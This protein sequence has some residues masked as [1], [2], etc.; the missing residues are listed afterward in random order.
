MNEIAVAVF[1]IFILGLLSL[2]FVKGGSR[3]YMLLVRKSVHFITGMVIFILTFHVGRDVLLA[4]IALGTVFSFVTWKLKG[5][6]FIHTTSG[7]SLGTLFYPLGILV[8]CML[9]YGMPLYYFQISLLVLA[10]SDTI[11]NLGG[12]I[13]PWN[14]RFAVFSEPKSV[15]GV[16]GFA[17]SALLI[18]ILLLPSPQSGNY[19]YIALF[20]IAAIH[21]EVLSHRGSDN[22]TIPVGCALFFLA[23]DGAVFN[24]LLPVLAIPAVAAGACMVYKKNVLTKYGAVAAYFLGVYF[25]CITGARWSVPVVV[26]FVTSV[27]F[28][29]ING[30]VN[31]KPRDTNRRNVWQVSANIFFAV[32]ASAGYLITGNDIFIHCYITL[33]AM[34]TAD[35]W[36]SEL[37]PIF[38]R[39]CFSLAE[40]RMA[41][42][43]TPGGI[44]FFGTGAALAGALMIT[45]LA[46][47]LFFQRVDI[48]LTAVMTCAALAGT[49]ADSLLSAFAE[50]GLSAMNF[51][52]HRA[53]PDSPSP[54]DIINLTAS[55]SAP[56]MYLLLRMI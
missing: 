37:G 48:E 2:K 56:V 15:F 1:I 7:E 39:R 42:S 5:F 16:A 27:V 30:R 25:F 46:Q 34:V 11:A 44:S 29:V 3:R 19:L 6:N 50:P 13:L 18:C 4:L 24:P 12:G 45:V 52:A 51:F 31:H 54:N 23:V 32:C 49:F 9:L 26:F 8:S 22:F 17:L 21:F 38:S 47:Y 40:W 20:L 41:D 33:V 43:G 35:T 28:T 55:L 10:V 36:A 53:G 14:T